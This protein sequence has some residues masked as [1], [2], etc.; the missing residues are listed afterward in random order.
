M[1]ILLNL[2]ITGSCSRFGG[3]WLRLVKPPSAL[4]LPLVLLM[5][6]GLS[7][8]LSEVFFFPGSAA[9]IQRPE[10]E[11]LILVQLIFPEWHEF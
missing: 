2:F 8:E 1:F 10:G 4:L 5:V 11:R 7:R 9:F 6:C 3:G